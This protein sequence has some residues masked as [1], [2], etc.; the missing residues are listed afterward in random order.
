VRCTTITAPEKNSVLIKRTLCAAPT[1]IV[2]LR[3]G[4]TKH[5]RPKA[6]PAERRLWRHLRARRL[7]GYTFRRQEPIGPYIADFVCPKRRLIIEIDGN[8]H[9]GKVDY[10]R[11]RTQYL[12]RLGYRVL[13]FPN[14]RVLLDTG[15]VSRSILRHLS[16]RKPAQIPGRHLPIL[17]GNQRRRAHRL[18]PVSPAMDPQ[19]PPPAL[20]VTAPDDGG[21][22]VP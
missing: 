6:T 5:L 21:T 2:A 4:S 3:I 16:P 11:V 9:Q 13:R 10:D 14:D 19:T 12:R 1:P 8:S 7:S 20:P 15:G 17:S 18:V 22:G